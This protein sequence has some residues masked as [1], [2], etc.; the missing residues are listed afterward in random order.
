MDNWKQISERKELEDR[1]NQQSFG[2]TTDKPSCSIQDRQYAC[3]HAVNYH[4]QKT[5][6][7]KQSRIEK[8][9]TD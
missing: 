3:Q 4:H 7:L 1:C 9:D 6:E 5:K 8:V 2:V